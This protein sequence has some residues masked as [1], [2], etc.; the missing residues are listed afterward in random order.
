MITWASSSD[1][2][3]GVKGGPVV[4]DIQELKVLYGYKALLSVLEPLKT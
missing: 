2:P 1:L 4:I 3:G